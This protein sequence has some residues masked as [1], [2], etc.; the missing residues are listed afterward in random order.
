MKLNLSFYGDDNYDSYYYGDDIRY[1]EID[2]D[3]FLNDFVD[4]CSIGNNI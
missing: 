2:E 1:G 3:F 4:I